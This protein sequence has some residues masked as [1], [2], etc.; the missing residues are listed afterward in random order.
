MPKYPKYPCLKIKKIKSWADP[1]LD[2]DI[3]Y[4]VLFPEINFEFL[5]FFI[6]SLMFA[7]S[8]RL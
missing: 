6:F 3:D 1:R 7:M 5:G 2:C 4:F 8:I